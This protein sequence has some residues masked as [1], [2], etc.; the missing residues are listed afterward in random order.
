MATKLV[1][2]KSYWSKHFHEEVELVSFDMSSGYCR[3][4]KML[5]ASWRKE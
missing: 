4:K 2:G 3:V 1:V 5:G